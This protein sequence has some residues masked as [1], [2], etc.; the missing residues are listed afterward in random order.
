MISIR[1]T[2]ERVVALLVHFKITRYRYASPGDSNSRA[3]REQ[4]LHI[5]TALML[6]GSNRIFQQSSTVLHSSH[7]IKTALALLSGRSFS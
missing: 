4:C 2:V 6:V 7:T 5:E 3:A 1:Y